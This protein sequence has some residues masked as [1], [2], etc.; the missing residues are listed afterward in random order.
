M[1]V[2]LD[3]SLLIFYISRSRPII[4]ENVPFLGQFWSQK[5]GIEGASSRMIQEYWQ[6]A[7]VAGKVPNLEKVQG[8]YM[9]R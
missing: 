6:G 1:E 7:N 4:H 3:G 5:L 9:V 8:Q 2:G